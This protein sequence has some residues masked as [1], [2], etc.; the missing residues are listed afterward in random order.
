MRA[1]LLAAGEG[2]RLRPYFDRPKPLVP[3]LGLPL[4]TR[5]ILALRECGIKEMVIITGCYGQ[6]IKEH[7]G[8]GEK[9]GVKINYIHNSRWELGNGTSAHAFHQAYRPGEKFILLMADH[10]FQ[11]DVLKTFIAAAQE[12]KENEILLAAD[13]QLEKVHD[14]A[15]CTKIKAE[16]EYALQLGKELSH[17]NAVDCGLF[18]GTGALLNAL[19]DAIAGQQYAL[20]DA[21]N[22][23][24][25]GRQVKLHF[26][27]GRWVDVDDEA[28]YKHCE[29]LL[30]QG[31][32]PAKDGFISRVLNRKFSLRITK[33]LAATGITPNQITLCSFLLTL[34]AA[35]SFAVGLPLYGGLLAQLSSIMDGVDGEIARLKFLS[36]RYG[37]LLDA[38]L[39]RY[40][41]FL[42]II[43]MTYGWYCVTNSEAALL[44]GAAAL[45]GAPMSMLFKEKFHALTGK[46]YL[47]ESYDGLG[48]YLPANRDG[49]LFIIMLGGILNLV[50]AA[51]ML[52][53]VVAHLQTVL[54]L[55]YGRR[56]M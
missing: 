21:V 37:G 38:I 6:E 51:L 41:D 45:T 49:R 53:A 39:D 43:G 44:V 50:P 46:P 28:S 52:L 23:L 31:L 5:N 4:I 9:L 30:L 32:V 33:L 1:V 42:L 55:W 13:K 56:L 12:I 24:A 35:A 40:G 11:P 15:E 25:K 47:P 10:I 26:V 16:Q 14:L 54:R 34:A 22:M 2:K 36:S 3:L 17:F 20:T 8:S 7:L 18:I 29:K 48:R 19:A 27:S